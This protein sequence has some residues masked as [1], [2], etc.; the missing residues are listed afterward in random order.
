MKATLLLRQ[1]FEKQSHQNSFQKFSVIHPDGGYVFIKGKDI[2]YAE[3]EGHGTNIYA[4]TLHKNVKYR[5]N[6][7]I[8]ELENDLTQMGLIRN[9]NSFMFNPEFMIQYDMEPDGVHLENRK[10]LPVSET[11]EQV[12]RVYLHIYHNH[13]STEKKEE[14]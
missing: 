6:E 10:Y 2:I 9:H 14:D 8:G 3:S 12:V 11:Y 4:V 1:Q 13:K 7:T 5:R